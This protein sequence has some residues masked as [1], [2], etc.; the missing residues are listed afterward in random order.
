MTESGKIVVLVTTSSEEESHRIATILLEQRTAACVNVI[1]KVASRYWWQ[2][3]LESAAESL[4]IIKTREALLGEL[5]DSV[6]KAHSYSVPEIVA[7]PIL[8]GNQDY[9]DWV[10]QEAA[11]MRG[12][13]GES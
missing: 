9:L 1:P 8:G 3:K 6:K 12:H 11:G 7:L 2:G 5:I 10:G 13:R 4:M